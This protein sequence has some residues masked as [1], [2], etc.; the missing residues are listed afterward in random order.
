MAAV[1][2]TYLYLLSAPNTDLP[3]KS[4][5]TDENPLRIDDSPFFQ[6]MRVVNL[7]AKPF[8]TTF[9]KDHDLSINEWRVL[10]ALANRGALA[11]HEI[12]A[13]TGMDKMNVSRA[14]RR[15]AAKDRLGRTADT[16]DRRR[17]LCSLTDEGRRV[18]MAIAPN[19]KRR[20]TALFAGLSAAESETLSR[21]LA[22]LERTAESLGPND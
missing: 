17:T 14:V 15:L 7:T 4:S 1:A 12:S 22:K 11:A 13:L 19:A 20:V 16:Q 6:L 8:F 3:T 5:H 9:G 2:E 21:L 18:Y 10:I